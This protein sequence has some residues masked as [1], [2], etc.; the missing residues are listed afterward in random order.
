MLCFTDLFPSSVLCKFDLSQSS[1]L[2]ILFLERSDGE[3][4]GGGGGGGVEILEMLEQN[5][6]NQDEYIHLKQAVTL[7]TDI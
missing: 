7:T 1:W 5:E 2:H 4:N 3:R 6:D